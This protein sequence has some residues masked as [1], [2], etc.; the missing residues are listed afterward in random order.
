M[1]NHKST[2]IKIDNNTIKYTITI[3]N[4]Q[5]L[6][7]DNETN[8]FTQKYLDLVNKKFN[9]NYKIGTS[10]PILILFSYN[11]YKKLNA[12]IYMNNIFDTEIVYRYIR[13]D[14]KLLNIP[15]CFYIDNP[16]S[17]NFFHFLVELLPYIIKLNILDTEIPFLISC[18][19]NYLDI[20]NY[21]GIKNPVIPRYENCIYLVKEFI[22]MES[23]IQ[24]SLDENI[25][26]VLEKFNN[27]KK[28]EPDKKYGI[29]IC[30]SKNRIILNFNQL[31]LYLKNN[32]KNLEWIIITDDMRPSNY[33]SYFIH[34][35]IIVA[36]HGAGLVNMMF[37]DKDVIIIEIMPKGFLNPCFLRLATQC[38]INRFHTIIL[39]DNDNCNNMIV[40]I[41]LFD[42]LV[43]NLFIDY[44]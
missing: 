5:C 26:L 28:V 31:E 7:I 1:Q 13:P 6:H 23:N 14:T 11:I 21:I 2:I 25:N 3:K 33:I 34:S 15:I 42:N 40:N 44:K 24:T 22:Y 41:E 29:I 27:V 18:N 9:L 17:P 16:W 43:K 12:I 37:C 10:D 39:N 20:L 4:N 32:Y 36:P 38:G 19:E 35:K 8:N 30:R